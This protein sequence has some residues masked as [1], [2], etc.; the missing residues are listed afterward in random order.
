MTSVVERYLADPL[1]AF[2]GT[3]AMT[4][5]TLADV[6]IKIVENRLSLLY[7][8]LWKVGWSFESMTGGSIP[9]EYMLNVTSN[10]VRP[11]PQTYAL[12]VPWLVLYFSSVGAMFL[13]AVASLVLHAMC[14]AP[15][16]LGYVSSLIR[17][18]VFFS[19]MGV[20]GNSTEDGSTKT[21]RLRKMEIKIADV[22]SEES[23]GR[24]AFAPAQGGGSVK[25][26]RWYDWSFEKGHFGHIAIF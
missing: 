21:S 20:Q 5:L 2:D 23:V 19:E 17:D 22:W 13:A 15:P 18:S 3:G 1:S 24:V 6:D 4:G 26:E 9:T 25:K 11:L 8:T 12:D 16:I 10:T 7:N 14:N